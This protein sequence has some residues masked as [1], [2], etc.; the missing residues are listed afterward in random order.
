MCQIL[1][2]AAHLMILSSVALYRL[3]NTIKMALSPES[4]GRGAVMCQPL[5]ST[6]S[7]QRVHRSGSHHFHV[8][9]VRMREE[10]TERQIERGR[11][12]CV[13]EKERGRVTR[14][15]STLS[16]NPA[17]KIV[18]AGCQRKCHIKEPQWLFAK[19]ESCTRL[20]WS[21]PGAT[22][23]PL[24]LRLISAHSSMPHLWINVFYETTKYVK[25]YHIFSFDFE[26]QSLL[27][28]WG[29]NTA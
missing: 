12:T 25:H 21:R 9:P 8:M 2:T 14:L 10:V 26:T 22:S 7:N 11:A 19:W 27:E 3:R 29:K 4:W 18:S 15:I 6:A 13:K 16:Q 17:H 5:N 23:E 28:S 1:H 24:T 20:Y